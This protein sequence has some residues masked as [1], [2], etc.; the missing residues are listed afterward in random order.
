MADG[1]AAFQAW[2][3]AGFSNEQPPFALPS[4]INWTTSY[5]LNDVDH[6]FWDRQLMEFMTNL[7]IARS[8]LSSAGRSVGKSSLLYDIVMFED[9]MLRK[10][11]SIVLQ[12]RLLMSRYMR[13]L[14]VLSIY[15]DIVQN[16]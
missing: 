7:S 10:M 12:R 8:T 5:Q 4:T 16:L 15:D 14:E 6:I 2:S 9:R 1:A 11:A 3:D 13:L